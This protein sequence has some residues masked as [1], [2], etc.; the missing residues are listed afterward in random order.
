MDIRLVIAKNIKTLRQSEGLTQAMLGEAV[1]Y[2]DKTVS[3]WERAELL[4][5]ILALKDIADYFGVSVD[6]LLSEEHRSK[7]K[8]TTGR[9]LDRR[10]RIIIVALANALIWLVA[11][12]FFAYHLILVPESDFPQWIA[13]IY[14]IPISALVT[15]I[16]NSV[17]GK[18][19]I[20]YLIISVLIWSILLSIYLSFI[21]IA[22]HNLWLVF[23]VGIPAEII[24]LLWSGINLSFRKRGEEDEFSDAP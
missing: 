23:I 15:L 19:R 12:F 7:E 2:S 14:A 5:D 20:N 18:R 13:F 6:Y 9:R 4:P 1:N 16:L 22:S 8:R 11:T 3:K 21:S 24:V 10:K 17:F